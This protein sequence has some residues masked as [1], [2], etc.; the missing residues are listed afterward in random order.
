MADSRPEDQDKPRTDLKVLWLLP[1]LAVGIGTLLVTRKKVAP[2][3][4]PM[5]AGISEMAKREAFRN[6]KYQVISQ[7]MQ[8]RPKS[9]AVLDFA[10]GTDDTVTELGRNRFRCSGF[11][12]ARSPTGTRLRERWECV[13]TASKSSWA[14]ESFRQSGWKRVPSGQAGRDVAG[15][16]NNKSGKQE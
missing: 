10:P 14:C 2:P 1:L 15:R 3:P 7:M 13:V 6:A 4:Q 11:L 12:V 8:E 16:G 9:V 5:Q